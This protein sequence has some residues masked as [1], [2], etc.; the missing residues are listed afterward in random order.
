MGTFLITALKNLI[1][2]WAANLIKPAVLTDLIILLAKAHSKRTD[3]PT[4][5]KVVAWMEEN[6]K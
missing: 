3:T 6:L 5:D 1:G 4:D 2:Y